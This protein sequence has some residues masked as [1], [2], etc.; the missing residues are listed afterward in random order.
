MTFQIYNDAGRIGEY[1][2]GIDTKASSKTFSDYNEITRENIGALDLKPGNYL[3]TNDQGVVVAKFQIISGTGVSA[4]DKSPLGKLGTLEATT[5]S[6]NTDDIKRI[7][8]DEHTHEAHLGEGNKEL[9]TTTVIDSTYT[10][11]G[12]K[13]DLDVIQSQNRG[14]T[15]LKETKASFISHYNKIG[16]KSGNPT[17]GQQ[18][19]DKAIS[20]AGSEDKLMM[21][22]LGFSMNI[23][24]D[25]SQYTSYFNKSDDQTSITG[26]INDDK[27]TK[28]GLQYYS[29][30]ELRFNKKENL[31][32]QFCIPIT[33]GKIDILELQKAS[34]PR[35]IPEG[36]FEIDHEFRKIPRQS[37]DDFKRDLTSGKI[38]PEVKG[39]VGNSQQLLYP[40]KVFPNFPIKDATGDISAFTDNKNMIYDYT[41]GIV[42]G[43]IELRI[44]IVNNKENNPDD[45]TKYKHVT[46]RGAA[47]RE[48]LSSVSFKKD[49]DGYH[50]GLCEKSDTT[51]MSVYDQ[52]FYDK[53]VARLNATRNAPSTTQGSIAE[54]K[55]ET[56]K[57]IEELK[58]FIAIV[59]KH[60]NKLY[61]KVKLDS[62]KTLGLAGQLKIDK[63][64]TG[65][66]KIT[67]LQIETDNEIK[68][69]FFE[70]V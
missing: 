45:S 12:E 40:Q 64:A 70:S 34:N 55:K 47:A 6:T 5:G 67:N 56:D 10:E 51:G 43:E 54:R 13:K 15:L 41:I 61:E 16:E 3:L 58:S 24:E 62:I 49:N 38:P 39:R 52:Y 35:P 48:Y 4:I 23:A 20:E 69:L 59:K 32:P 27:T 28:G 18:M 66:E 8:K 17:T 11:N 29:F 63:P 21:L 36:T 57:N 33:A 46:L 53:Y 68:K 30:W 50:R 19:W 7:V 25:K 14:Q 42:N 9:F 1:D 22:I 44:N 60:N 37:S 65:G 31:K 26:T 2:K